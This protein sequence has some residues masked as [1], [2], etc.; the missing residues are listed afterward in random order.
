MFERVG[1]RVGVS[2]GF[3]LI[4]CI[5]LQSRSHYALYLPV[6]VCNIYCVL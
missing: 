2:V 4:T 3:L 5:I 6:M 1:L